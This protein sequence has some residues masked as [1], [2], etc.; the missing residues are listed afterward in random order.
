MGEKLHNSIDRAINLLATPKQYDKYISIKLSPPSGCCCSHCWPKTWQI[1]NQAIAPCGPVEHEG[2]ALIEKDGDRFVLESH[3][4]GPEIILY[5]ALVTASL[6]VT[7][8]VIDLVNTII[9]G[10]SKEKRKQPA[11]LKITKRQIIKGKIEE[12]NIMEIDIPISEGMEKQL[13]EKIN[14]AINKIP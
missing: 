13:E 8:S 7:K 5:L 10:L 9:K 12:E 4:S 1:I 3:E 2:D 6:T 11:R 14:Q